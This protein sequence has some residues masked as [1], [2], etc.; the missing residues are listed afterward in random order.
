MGMSRGQGIAMPTYH[1]NF[2]PTVSDELAGR[3]HRAWT[4]WSERDSL[5]SR[6]SVNDVGSAFDSQ[7]RCPPSSCDTASQN[8]RR[9]QTADGAQPA[10]HL[11]LSDSA[12]RIVDPHRALMTGLAGRRITASRRRPSG[13]PS[14]TRRCELLAV[15]SRGV[16]SSWS[17]RS[18]IRSRPLE[19]SY[20]L[21]VVIVGDGHRS[22]MPCTSWASV[23]SLSVKANVSPW[24]G[25]GVVADGDVRTSR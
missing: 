11:H 7:R 17:A 8:G 10:S 3:F 14:S 25:G 4:S 23:R 6:K 22:Q 9:N 2:G 21:K 24:F 12:F 20:K 18:E 15:R 13:R 5:A 1:Q 16:E 19:P